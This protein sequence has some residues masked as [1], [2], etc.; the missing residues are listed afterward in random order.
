MSEKD[1]NILKEWFLECI[2]KMMM[3]DIISERN[4]SDK[5]HR[6]ASALQNIIIKYE[7]KGE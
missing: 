6:K 3:Y 5:Y 1:I 4:I 7:N 2:G